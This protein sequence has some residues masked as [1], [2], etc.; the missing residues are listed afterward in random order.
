MD[1]GKICMKQHQSNYTQYLT[2]DRD[3]SGGYILHVLHA[4]SNNDLSSIKR[5]QVTISEDGKSLV[6]RT[7]G[8]TVWDFSLISS[9]TNSLHR[10]CILA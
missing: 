8:G 5:W 9:I 7:E 2:V 10:L 6:P 1:R 3:E 4:A